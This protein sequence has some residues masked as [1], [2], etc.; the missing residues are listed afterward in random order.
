MVERMTNRFIEE[1]AKTKRDGFDLLIKAMEEGGFFEAPC[2]GKHHLAEQYGL[3]QHSLNVLD[4]A[5]KLNETWGRI[6]PDDSVIIVSLLHDLGKMGDHG[7]P[8]YVENVLKSGKVSSAEPFKTNKDLMYLPHEVRS[9]IIAERYIKLKEDEEQAIIWHNGLYGEFKYDIQGK[10]TP[11]Y[12]LLHFAD[13]W[14]S[15]VVEIEDE[16]EGKE[17]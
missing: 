6:V 11:I 7:K 13:M 17:E 1:M 12:M 4:F 14:C 2:S 9:A 10:E 3:L 5:R 16:D 15:R 8:N